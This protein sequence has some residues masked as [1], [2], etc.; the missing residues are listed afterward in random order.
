MLSWQDLHSTLVDR[1]TQ[2]RGLPGL[3][4]ACELELDT[5]MDRVPT[6]WRGKRRAELLQLRL[7]RVDDVA[8]AGVAQPCQITGIGQAPMV[9]TIV[10]KVCESWVL[11]ANTS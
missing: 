8:P 11:P 6:V 4:M 7:R 5:L 1:T 3:V 2:Y 9:I 10:C